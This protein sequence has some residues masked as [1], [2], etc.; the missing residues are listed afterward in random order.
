MGIVE[1]QMENQ[2]DTTGFRDDEVYVGIWESCKELC[3]HRGV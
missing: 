2:T 1:N 3:L